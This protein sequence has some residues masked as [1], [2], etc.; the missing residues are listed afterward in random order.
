MWSECFLSN[1]KLRLLIRHHLYFLL[2]RKQ[3]QL[4]FSRFFGSKTN[5]SSLLK[6]VVKTHLVL[7]TCSRNFPK[8]SS[9]TKRFCISHWP[10]GCRGFI[11]PLC[12]NF[13]FPVVG[14][15]EPAEP[16]PTSLQW[17]AECRH[18][19]LPDCMCQWTHSGTA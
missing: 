4:L 7:S 16:S 3:T 5:V 19:P 12:H 8:C 10:C 14:V 2:L 13:Y 17:E 6:P 11:C 1:R 18:K 15:D 9:I